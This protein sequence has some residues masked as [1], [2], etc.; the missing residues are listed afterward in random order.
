MFLFFCPTRGIPV[1]YDDWIVGFGCCCWDLSPVR[2]LP[3]GTRNWI[4]HVCIQ[5]SNH[6]TTQGWLEIIWERC[7]ILPL[8]QAFQNIVLGCSKVWIMCIRDK[9][10]KTSAWLKGHICFL[11][12]Q[13]PKLTSWASWKC[14][15]IS[16]CF[17][18]L[19][20]SQCA[21]CQLPSPPPEWS[22][23]WSGCSRTMPFVAYSEMC[24]AEAGTPL[25]AHLCMY[26]KWLHC[27]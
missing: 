21:G 2:L 3:K 23:T 16:K 5:H 19:V 18:A 12:L 26:F 9:L 11:G 8:L 4:S 17:S 20:P 10:E 7:N 27:F 6:C 15:H 24:V 1:S 13:T 14:L 22:V 25:L